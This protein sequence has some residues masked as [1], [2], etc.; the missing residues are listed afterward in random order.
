M[1]IIVNVGKLDQILRFVLSL[2]MIYF[3]F[4]SDRL[5]ADQLAGILLGAFGVGIL[6]TAIFKFCPLYVLIG[7]NSCGM[8][9]E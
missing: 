1:K 6:L 7:F 2:S 3:G 9:K 5:I 4:F 8:K